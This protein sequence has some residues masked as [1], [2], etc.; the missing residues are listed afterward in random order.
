MIGNFNKFGVLALLVAGCGGVDGEPGAL[1]QEEEL[2]Q[3]AQAF[4][5]ATNPS[6]QFGTR[7][8]STKQRCNFNDAQICSVPPAKSLSYC[9][10]TGALLGGPD[11]FSFTA[12]QRTRVVNIIEGFDSTSD[13]TLTHTSVSDC[14]SELGN[15]Q[16]KV[17]KSPVGALGTASNEIKDY[18]DPV[19]SGLTNLTEGAGVQG[20]YQSW[21]NC[22]MNIDVAD[23][24]AKGANS[25]EDNNVL[26][27]AS[28]NSLLGCLGI[29]RRSTNPGGLGS[30]NLVA[31]TIAQTS[32]STGEACALQHFTL[33]NPGQYN[34]AFACPTD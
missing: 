5:G 26:D 19:F 20:D 8:S 9:V 6:N 11:Q 32:V 2:G 17:F 7:T 3:D 31:P 18:A 23:I 27:H 29:G 24:L 12:A 30:R 28:K 16:I 13:F 34:Q 33:S 10:H 22:Q 4:G 15:G 21:T 14:F 1:S 25:T